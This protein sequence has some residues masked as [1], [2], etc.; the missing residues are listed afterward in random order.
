MKTPCEPLGKH[1]HLVDIRN[2]QMKSDCLLGIN[3]DKYFMPSV[4]NVIGTDLSRY[5]LISKGLFACNPMHVGRDGRLP[6]ALYMD[7]K[8]SIVSPAYFMFKIIDENFLLPEY[9]MMWF[10]RTEF[11]RICWLKTDGSVRG[12][13]SWDDICRMELLVPPLD[14]QKAIVKAYQ[15]ITDRITLKR[16][17]NDNLLATLQAIYRERFIKNFDESLATGWRICKLRDICSK[18]GSGATPTGGKTEYQSFGISLI[19]STNVFDYVFSYEDLAHIN[20][21]QAKALSNVVVQQNDILFNITGVSVARCCIVPQNVLPARV[22]QHVMIIRASK[23]KYL[24]FY[25]L[26]TLCATENKKKLLGIG[27]SG[28]TREAINKQELENFEIVLPDLGTLEDFGRYAVIL[29]QQSV[30]NSIEVQRLSEL[31][32]ILLS[33]LAL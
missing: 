20:D 25:L 17:I 4:A 16:K 5:K 27:Q 3:I 30:D 32:A 8:P 23:N 7:D 28:S 18:I 14:K 12:G 22:N 21:D 15:T 2:T 31:Q 9:L 24:N 29:Y 19:R 26:C 1:I 33:K 11:D 10:Q 6:I 13:L